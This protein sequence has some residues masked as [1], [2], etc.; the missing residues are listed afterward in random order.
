MSAR[1][2]DDIITEYRELDGIY[3]R[4]CVGSGFCCT[5][6]PCGF[7]AWN[8]EHS[9]CTFLEQPN[10]YGQR[11]CGKYEEIKTLTPFWMYYPAFGGGCSSPVGNIKREEV[12]KNLPTEIRNKIR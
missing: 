2:P 9:A 5:K 11:G 12:I 1:T 8:A 3:I 4:P 7:G 6:S 10:E